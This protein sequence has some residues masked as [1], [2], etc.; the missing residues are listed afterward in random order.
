MIDVMPELRSIGEMAANGDYS[1]AMDRLKSLWDSIPEPKS[2]CANVYMLI[3]YAV[4]VCMRSGD[5]DEAWRWAL[6]APE[7]NKKRQDL[8]EA[9]FLI[10]KVAFERGDFQLAEA[11]FSIANHKSNGRIFRGEDPK[12]RA[13]ITGR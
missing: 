9:E 13:L 1:G 12:Y 6:L 2:E 8:G 7:Y 4:A 11:S 5:I 3:E 10:G